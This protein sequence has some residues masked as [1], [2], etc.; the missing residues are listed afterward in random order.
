MLRR[1]LLAGF[2]AAGAARADERT[3]ILE[4]VEPLAAA[5]SASRPENF[6]AAFADDMPDR[7]RLSDHI[8]ALIAFAEVT[9]SIEVIGIGGGRAELDWYMEIR[10]RATRSIVER[11]RS[12]VSVRVSS[13]KIQELKPV[14]FFRLPQ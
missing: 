8:G 4:I 14:D 2:L 9:S 3:E 1:R 6:M 11:R 10:A 13:G 7:G 12:K 5:L